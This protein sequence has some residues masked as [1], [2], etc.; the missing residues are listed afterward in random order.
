M[1]GPSVSAEN[2]DL[3][4]LV[5]WKMVYAVLKST[6]GKHSPLMTLVQPP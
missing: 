3:G 4:T 5:G 6:V 1:V 2:T